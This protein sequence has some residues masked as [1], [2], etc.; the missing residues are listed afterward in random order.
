MSCDM[1]AA[2]GRGCAPTCADYSRAVPYCDLVT[3]YVMTCR[4]D[5]CA[6]LLTNADDMTTLLTMLFLN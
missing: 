2:H 4:D 3:M 5:Y 6:V 1:T